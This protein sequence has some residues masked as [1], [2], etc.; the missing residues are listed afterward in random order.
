MTISLNQKLGSASN[1]ATG[2]SSVARILSV[3]VS[4]GDTIIIGGGYGG[5]STVTITAT[6][7][8]NN[9]YQVDRHDDLTSAA[10]P[11]SF[12]LSAAVTTP[13]QISDTITVSFSSPVN[14][15]CFSAYDYSGLPSS[16]WVDTSGGATG[17]AG[18]ALSTG[19]ITTARTNDLLFASAYY[20]NS[21]SPTFTAGSGYTALDTILLIPKDATT[22][23]GTS[24]AAGTYAATATLSQANDWAISV[25]AYG[26]TAARQPSLMMM[27]VGS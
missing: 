25:V 9:T 22:E 2:I 24:T 23:S 16:S 21:S 1:N 17:L 19:N 15:P 26:A 13:L 27:G 11:H 3:A 18:T 4:A 20:G 7:S 10:T 12:V 5:G 14:Y 6:D 8:R